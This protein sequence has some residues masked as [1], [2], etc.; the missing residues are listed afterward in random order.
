ML[1][2]DNLCRG[3]GGV[4]IQTKPQQAREKRE[5]TRKVDLQISMKILF[6]NPSALSS[7]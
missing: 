1:L 7:D 3:G 4:I 6:H 5:K 2:T